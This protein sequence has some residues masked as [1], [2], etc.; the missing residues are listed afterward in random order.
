MGVLLELTLL[1]NKQ[2]AAVARSAFYLLWLVYPLWLLLEMKELI[3]IIHT[4]VT[5]SLKSLHALCGA[6]LGIRTEST[7]SPESSSKHV[8]GRQKVPTH[9]SHITSCTGFQCSC[10]PGT[11]FVVLVLN[12]KALYG[13]GR[14]CLKDSLLQY[15]LTCALVPPRRL[16]RP[17]IQ[18]SLADGHL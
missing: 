17:V 12:C 16:L 5:S 15:H 10:V 2:V 6:D 4:L 3:M 8:G 14:G 13:L 9:N 7:E 18:V 11:E 1:L